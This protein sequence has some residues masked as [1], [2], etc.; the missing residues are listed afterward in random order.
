MSSTLSACLGLLALLGLQSPTAEVAT[1]GAADPRGAYDVRSY[2]LDFEVDPTEQRLLAQT[3]LEAVVVEEEL[4]EIVLDL[5]AELEPERAFSIAGELGGSAALTGARLEFVREEHFVRVRLPKPA[6]R[7]ETVRVAVAASGK[8]RARGDF[9]GFHWAK[10][11]DGSPWINTSCQGTGSSAWWACKDSFWHPEDKPER[12]WVHITVPKGLY[13]VS[14]GRLEGRAAA[15]EGWETFRW[16]HDYPLETYSV[17]LNVAPYVVV[18][19]ELE[20]AN[21]PSGGSAAGAGGS[22]RFP[23]IYYVLPEDQEKARVQFAE[24]PRMIE[25]YSRAFGPFPFPKSKFGLV[26]TNFWG[27]EHSTA[28]AYGSSF[29]AWCKE[30]GERDAYAGRNQ[31]FDYIL[32]HEPAHEWW[33]NGVSAADWADFW[34]HEGFAT[35]AE[36]VFVEQTQGREA[37][38]RFFAQQARQVPSKGS[39]YRGKGKNSE[40]AYGLILY[41]KGACVL[42]TLRHELADDAAWWRTLR[43]FNLAFRYRNATTDDFRSVLEKETGRDWKRFFDEWIYGRGYPKLEGS[44]QVQDGGILVQL[45]NKGTDGTEFHVPLD[46]AWV[47]NGQPVARRIALEPGAT[48]LKLECASPPSELRVADLGGI[49]GRHKVEAR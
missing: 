26:E 46:L 6:R 44:V 2:R 4:G 47:E 42:N 27:M 31:F 45:A 10:T 5:Q 49:L 16:F 34:I 20:I 18:E 22:T 14:N 38:D 35:Y 29:P 19:R 48:E 13:A 12:V 7:G 21:D 43:S 41:V 25:I 37:A 11:A 40:E 24:V 15:R 30:H 9:D 1:A 23:F 8:P 3:A 36:G 17:T 33:G 39:L 32:I 28:V